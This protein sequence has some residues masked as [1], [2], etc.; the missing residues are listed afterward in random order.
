MSTPPPPKLRAPLT[1][2]ARAELVATGWELFSALLFLSAVVPA[3]LT[4]P[5]PAILLLASMALSAALSGVLVR[6]GDRGFAIAAA[7]RT[8]SWPLAVSPLALRGPPAGPPS[9]PGPLGIGHA[10]PP[11]WLGLLVTALAFGVMAG[12]MRLAIHRSLLRA[13][14]ADGGASEAAS[15]RALAAALRPRLAE[16]AT[17]AGIVG[18]HVMLLF[19]VAFLRTQSQVVFQA[20]FEVV[21]LLALSG[22]LGFTFAVRPAT[23]AIVAALR[24]GPSGDRALLARGLA[25][26][27]RL[28]D[29]LASLNFAL[30]LGCTAIGIAYV[31]PGATFRPGAP[32]SAADALMQLGFGALFAFGVSFYQR[33]WHRDS[34]ARAVDLLRAW[35]GA[36]ERGGAPPTPLR[37][38]MLRDFG[39][40]LLF[41]GLL[42]LFSSIGLYRALATGS[43]FNED[44][45][46]ITALFASFS[47]LVLAALGVVARAAR[48]L[49]RPMA[50]LA[51]AADEVARGELGAAVPRLSGPKEVV[52]LGESVERMRQALSRTIDELE[53]ERAG[54]EENV[55][56][57]TA[58]L[59]RALS[60][61][62]RTQAALIQG[63]RLASIG[64]LV[65]GV[66]HEIYN[67]LNAIA[68]AA[69][70]IEELAAELRAVLDAYRAAERELP[71]DRRRALEALREQL[72]TE[73][74]LEDLVGISTLVHRAVE[75]SVRIVANLKSF[76]RVSGEP[77]PVDLH[78]G[79]EETLLLL[80][81][82]LRQARIEVVRRYG[83]LPPVTCRSGEINQ[84]FMNLLVNAI[85]A[86]EEASAAP[87]APV[88]AEAAEGAGGAAEG[89][90]GAPVICV[91]TW[92]DED[93]AA[94]AIS[95]SGPGV[96]PDLAQRIFDPFFTTKPRGHGTGL[97]L[98]ISTDIV[99]RHGGTL[100]L[101]PADGRAG[102]LRCG[103]PAGARFVCRLPLDP[104]PGSAR[105]QGDAPPPA[106][107]SSGGGSAPRTVEARPAPRTAEA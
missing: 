99:R 82:R 34:V 95:D 89:P 81:P 61:L 28:P 86:L 104:R 74:A 9:W 19:C 4:T 96:P 11:S 93:M 3:A 5:W 69:Q 37:R 52:G 84:V 107:P 13:D 1:P 49:S 62:K 33:A 58:E 101:A 42:S 106:R 64:E 72:Q 16:S 85:Q 47:L 51:R 21:P 50:Q 63:E 92:I 25:R 76:S 80:G 79:L 44:F 88:G 24:A 97:G 46:A 40:P 7:I 8:L 54:L 65:A 35:T 103:A 77:L 71:D 87:P 70:P 102:D 32:F 15:A 45:N 20:W 31:R 27:E 55:A 23:H 2:R 30:W 60:E 18:G 90:P 67:P 10:T 57:R 29:V 39:L 38:R 26:A 91:E 22:T 98:S 75:R 100:A 83:D 17:A 66:A 36:P 48:E 43:S 73:A 6:R 78:A 41:T 53:G 14:A 12:G 59:T 105:P 68:G 56:A 94:V